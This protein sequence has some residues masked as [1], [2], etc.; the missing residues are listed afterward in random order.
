MRRTTLALLSCALGD[1]ETPGV[2]RVLVLVFAVAPL[3]SSRL[4]HVEIAYAF[5]YAERN[6]RS[7]QEP[8]S[9]RQTAIY[10]KFK[11][12]YRSSSWVMIAA[13]ERTETSLD[14]YIKSCENITQLNPFEI[15]L[16]VLDTILANWRPYIVGLTER[17]TQQVRPISVTSPPP[18]HLPYTQTDR[19]L[20][21]SIDEK[22]PLRFADFEERQRLKD[23]ED[24]L[25][26]LLLIFDATHD[27]IT[28]LLDRYKDFCIDYDSTSDGGDMRESDFL[29]CAFQ[30]RQ[31]DVCTSRNKVKTLH[32][33]VQGTTSLVSVQMLEL[34]VR[35]TLK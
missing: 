1:W 24:R 12:T 3:A 14:R 8:W 16:V 21:A 5:R 4:I 9:I 29:V 20:V 23:F 2:D 11:A 30:E 31:K 22:D 18:F 33:K 7:V 15:H 27:T 13:S 32:T 26:D 34:R 10:Q 25:I 17:I 19:V 35:L 28:S 6:N